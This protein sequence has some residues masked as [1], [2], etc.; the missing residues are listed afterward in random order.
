V[1]RRLEAL[2]EGRDN[3]FADAEKVIFS[4]KVNSKK[5]AEILGL[6]LPDVID[7]TDDEGWNKFQ[8]DGDDR[9][10]FVEEVAASFLIQTADIR[11]CKPLLKL[12]TIA[13][14]PG[15]G[16]F[17]DRHDFVTDQFI[18]RA[19]GVILLLPTTHY[20]AL[21]VQRIIQKVRGIFVS[22]YRSPSAAL[23]NIAFVVNCYPGRQSEDVIRKSVADYEES[24]R[25]AFELSPAEWRRRQ[26]NPATTN[27]FAV[28]LKNVEGGE[29]PHRVYDRPS[30]TSLR[31]WI[32]RLFLSGRY[33][34]RLT[35]IQNVLVGEW[36]DRRALLDESI[37]EF[38]ME[39][40]GVEKRIAAVRVFRE[41][42]LVNTKRRYL[43]EITD[44]KSDF[45]T[46]DNAIRK[47]I[48]RRLD[49][50]VADPRDK[51]RLG[52]LKEELKEL[53]RELN[54]RL[55][56]LEEN[57]PAVGWAGTMKRALGAKH[58]DAPSLVPPDPQ[59][60]DIPW[61][62]TS[63][64][65]L[66]SVDQKFEEIEQKW[67]NWLERGVIYVKTKTVGGEDVRLTMAKELRDS[68]WSMHYAS[69]WNKRLENYLRRSAEFIE[70]KTLE[71]RK[72]CLEREKTLREQ[73]ETKK[74]E[75]EKAVGI[76]DSFEASR[77]GFIKELETALD[78]GE[79]K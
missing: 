48:E 14:T 47:R 7:L 59:K 57:D 28:K 78:G 19:E 72:K 55:G 70:T 36:K 64:F 29:N 1:L 79:S 71:A 5:R 68:F 23:N 34:K 63:R 77:K 45:A 41:S 49:G 15:T 21:R 26:S 38:G 43:E 52:T 31:S 65:D 8:G 67:P 10:P 42:E 37:R 74:K 69:I 9:L 54:E 39:A 4:A 11:L 6:K 2:E 56:E 46:G 44:F 27:F 66:Q 40:R 24:V 60:Q 25:E 51:T 50:F 20:H 33:R 76:F 58:V 61:S 16:S 3:P 35:E 75:L 22:R 18:H 13:D 30:L 32:R 53:Y 12:T 17:N 73:N 62:A